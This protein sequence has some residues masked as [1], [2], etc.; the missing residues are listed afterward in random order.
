MKNVLLKL[1]KCPLSTFQTSTDINQKLGLF[2]LTSFYTLYAFLFTKQMSMKKYQHNV[3]LLQPGSRPL[4]Q[5]ISICVWKP[6]AVCL[7]DLNQLQCSSNK[8]DWEK[9][10]VNACRMDHVRVRFIKLYTIGHYED[11]S[12]VSE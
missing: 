1:T 7:L 10:N 4:L 2:I 5:S 9:K 8:R 6:W 12:V 3:I 11:L